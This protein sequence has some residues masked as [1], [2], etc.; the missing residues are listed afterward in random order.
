MSAATRGPS[1]GEI[2]RRGARPIR[3]GGEKC[4]D[5]I[6]FGDFKSTDLDMVGFMGRSSLLLVA[7]LSLYH[8]ALFAVFLEFGRNQQMTN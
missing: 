5:L 1:E 2:A 7:S 3:F 8:F 4:R 6:K